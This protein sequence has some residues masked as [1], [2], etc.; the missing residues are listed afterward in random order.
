MS[1]LTRDGTAESVSRDQTL[2]RE[3]RQ[4]SI[5]FLC[6]ADHEQD[7]QPCSV[8][9]YS[10]KPV[11]IYMCDDHTAIYCKLLSLA[12][13]SLYCVSHSLQYILCWDNVVFVV[14]PFNM[15]FNI[16]CPY[17]TLLGGV[18]LG[19]GQRLQCYPPFVSCSRFMAAWV[20]EEDKASEHRQRRTKLRFWGGRSKLKMI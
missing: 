14:S 4:G 19:G 10:T 18:L 1:R 13:I 12:S 9:Q 3:R 5:N 6:S 7:R 11:Y 17:G 20:R 8:D 16:V 15:P 2:R